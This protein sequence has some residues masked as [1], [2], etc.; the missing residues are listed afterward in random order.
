V[1]EL[2]AELPDPELP[3]SPYS[4]LDSLRERATILRKDHSS[5]SPALAGSTAYMGM[6][7]AA[8]R[9]NVP[10]AID[11]R[12]FRGAVANAKRLVAAT[13][14]D[15]DA[16]CLLGH[17]YRALSARRAE[18]TTEESTP[19]ARQTAV[20]EQIHRS[21][22]G[23]ELTEPVKPG[24]EATRDA[25]QAKAAE[26]LRKAARLDPRLARPHLELA[27]LYATQGH[28][29]DAKL[30]F[31]RYLELDPKGANAGWVSEQ[32]VALKESK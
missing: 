14:E 4:K 25:N 30:E 31:R 17:A 20:E 10:M 29:D 19:E 18:L 1:L 5:H 21:R 28:A 23:E 9:E 15:A 6:V 22:K 8:V 11:S 3:L 26:L 24:W 7:Q 16:N 2:L 27:L 13:P 12:R 32:F